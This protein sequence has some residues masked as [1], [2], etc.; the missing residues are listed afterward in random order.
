[1]NFHE[2]FPTFS[3]F[4]SQTFLSAA[5]SFQFTSALKLYL[6]YL[7]K[8]GSNESQLNDHL[9]LLVLDLIG[10]VSCRVKTELN[11]STTFLNFSLFFLVK[12][13]S[14]LSE[15]KNHEDQRVKRDF[16]SR[17]F[18][19]PC[20]EVDLNLRQSTRAFAADSFD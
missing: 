15:N 1:M 12:K 16:L 13:V 14:F 7:N 17:E 19:S 2:N 4:S 9:E 3:Q 11:S 6:I 18:V 20:T 10:R 8:F 5:K